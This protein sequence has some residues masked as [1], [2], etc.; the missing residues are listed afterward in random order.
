MARC[1]FIRK[2]FLSEGMIRPIIIL[3]K[4]V[5]KGPDF[6]RERQWGRFREIFRI[7]V[8]VLVDF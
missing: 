7:K 3:R 8:A 1:T 2:G 6:A 5:V 4:H